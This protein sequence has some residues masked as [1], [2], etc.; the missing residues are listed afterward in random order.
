SS[1]VPQHRAELLA[2]PTDADGDACATGDEGEP[3]IGAG[4]TDRASRGNAGELVVQRRKG[5]VRIDT[6]IEGEFAPRNGATGDRGENTLFVRVGRR[7]RRI[8][9]RRLDVSPI[10]L[11]GSVT[12][13]LAVLSGLSAVAPAWFTTVSA[14]PTFSSST[15]AAISRARTRM[16]SE[17]LTMSGS[18]LVSTLNTP[19]RGANL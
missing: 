9:R 14:P 7:H 18:H 13:S 16:R 10:V 6:K 11:P 12:R 5:G 8:W 17:P 1:F 4:L 19:W 2:G 3:H 15:V